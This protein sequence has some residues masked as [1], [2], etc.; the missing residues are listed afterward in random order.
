MS[1]E[2]I[3]KTRFMSPLIRWL[4][5]ITL[6]PPAYS[7]SAAPLSTERKAEIGHIVQQD[8]G[9][10]HG[11][12]LK[13]GLGPSLDPQRLNLYPPGFLQTTILHGRPGTPMPPWSAILSPSDIEYIASQLRSGIWYVP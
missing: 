13:G 4:L 7:S 12:T 8:C 6:L 11:L 9:S 5:F 1:H 3:D 2:P 10:C